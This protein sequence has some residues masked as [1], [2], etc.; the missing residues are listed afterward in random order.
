[1][2]LD[3]RSNDGPRLLA[4]IGS[5][6]SGS[7]SVERR[8]RDLKSHELG[9]LSGTADFV[10]DPDGIGFAER[11]TLV[12]PHA[13]AEAQQ[14]YRFV[15][16]DDHSFSV[17]FA[18]GRFFHRAD[19]AAGRASVSHGCPPDTYRGRY[20]FWQPSRW[21]LSWRITGPRKDLVIGTVFSRIGGG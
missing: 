6:F 1:M 17:F 4:A 18:D 8:I 15:I 9:R 3:L 7:W 14:R 16:E 21:S 12:L 2:P 10:Q 11:G 19:I 5:F 13:R 20:R